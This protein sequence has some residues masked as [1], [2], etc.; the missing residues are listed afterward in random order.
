MTPSVLPSTFKRRRYGLMDRN[1]D[2]PGLG[3]RIRAARVA[4]GMSQRALAEALDTD[5]SSIWKWE[6]AGSVPGTHHLEGLARVLG[7]TRKRLLYGGDGADIPSSE[8]P[9]QAWRDFVAG[10]GL[11]D[12]PGWAVEGL[13]RLRFGPGDE[14]TE[15]LYRMTLQVWLTGVKRP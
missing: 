14:P 3:A 10:G 7:V 5:K 6:K 2:Y 4:A 8:P 13:R 11:D 1:A 15:M 12:A 9:Y